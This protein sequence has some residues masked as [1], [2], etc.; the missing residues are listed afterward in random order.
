M[1]HEA[2]ISEISCDLSLNEFYKEYC[3]NCDRFTEMWWHCK[4][5]MTVRLLY[6]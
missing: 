5:L 3:D 1:L 6:H 2:G 4:L